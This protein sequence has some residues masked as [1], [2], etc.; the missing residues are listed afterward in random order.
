M[1]C[2]VREHHGPYFAVQTEKC[3]SLC[4]NQ[5][6]V[7]LFNYYY[8]FLCWVNWNSCLQN[9]LIILSPSRRPGRP[10][11]LSSAGPGPPAAP[12][13]PTAVFPCQPAF[14]LL[15][16]ASFFHLL[17]FV[18]GFILSA[19]PSSVPV[20]LSQPGGPLQS[21]P[22]APVF[23]AES[24]AG[25]HRAASCAQASDGVGRKGQRPGWVVRGVWG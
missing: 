2:D 6:C 11:G 1:N 14:P 24:G 13:Q 15:Q 5:T 22:G 21:G 9:F 18:S 7:Y 16:L 25:T 10:C 4:F 23:G 12:L 3:L 19:L 20:W 8:N 17:T